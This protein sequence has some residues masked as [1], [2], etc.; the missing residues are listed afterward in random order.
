[1]LNLFS[2]VSMKIMSLSFKRVYDQALFTFLTE[3]SYNNSRI[4]FWW[5]AWSHRLNSS[6]YQNQFPYWSFKKNWSCIL[7][8]K[9]IWCLFKNY[10]F[11][12]LLVEWQ[13]NQATPSLRWLNYKQK[14]C[15][16][17]KKRKKK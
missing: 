5:L 8:P 2:K 9:I 14:Y 12:I 6:L 16:K 11:N 13:V 1:L 7:F 15:E 10:I 3:I 17:E 4:H